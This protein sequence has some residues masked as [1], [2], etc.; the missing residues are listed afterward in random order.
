MNIYCIDTLTFFLFIQAIG[1]LGGKTLL[2]DAQSAQ[3][4][5]LDKSLTDMLNMVRVCEHN[6]AE[7][8][9][10]IDNIQVNIDKQNTI[11]M[12]HENKIQQLRDSLRQGKGEALQ[13]AT[14][15]SDHKET[16]DKCQKKIEACSK[17]IVNMGY[18]MEGIEAKAL[19]RQ[20]MV[21]ELTQ[22]LVGIDCKH[23][24]KM[25]EFDDHMAIQGKQMTKYDGQLANMMESWQ[26]MM[27]R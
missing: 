11:K 9:E 17:E 6:V 8:S 2:K 26:N 24:K 15:L 19:E 12:E 25:K 1:R 4:I 7:H 5:V 27:N 14:E 10:K 13:L 18:I 22:H 16:I 3:H 20:E 23:D 21:D